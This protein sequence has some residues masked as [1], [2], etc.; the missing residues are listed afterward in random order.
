[1][2]KDFGQFSESANPGNLI[3][4]MLILDVI[5]IPDEEYIEYIAFGLIDKMFYFLDP[6]FEVIG[7]YETIED[8]LDD[9]SISMEEVNVESYDGLISKNNG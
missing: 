1:M 5:E 7:E 4:N 6:D 9:N 8:L 2:I 3:N